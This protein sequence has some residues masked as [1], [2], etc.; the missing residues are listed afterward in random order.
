MMEEDQEQ[1]FACKFCDKTFA[2]GKSLGGHMRGHLA[3]ISSQ[4]AEEIDNGNKGFEGYGLRHNQKKALKVLEPLDEEEKN[5]SMGCEDGYYGLRENPK[6]SWRASSSSKP[7]VLVK[8]ENIITNL[9]KE[10]GKGFPSLRALSGHMRC[11]SI[12]GKEE[13]M[14]KKCG[15]G[16]DS[17]RALFGHMRSHSKR[18]R[19]SLDESAEERK[20]DYEPAF[21]IPKKRLRTRYKVT[22][23]SN[24]SCSNL[25]ASCSSSIVTGTDNEVEEVAMCL[26]LLSRG[27]KNWDDFNSV[28]NTSNNDSVIL[29]AQSL[30]KSHG[31]TEND[32]DDDADER[33][34]PIENALIVK[35]VSEFCLLES[36]SAIDDL[37]K[38]KL[39]V[40]VDEFL[41]CDKSK[42]PSQD[43]EFANECVELELEK[44]MVSDLELNQGDS[45]LVKSSPFDEPKFDGHDL[46]LGEN[47]LRIQ[48]H[49]DSVEH[50][51]CEVMVAS[52]EL[53]KNK[54]H[55]CSICFKVFAS[56]QALGG[57]KRAHY[58]DQ[59]R[60]KEAMLINQELP[61]IHNMFDLNLPLSLEDGAASDVGFKP[62]WIG[63]DH[64]YEPLVMFN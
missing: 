59:T 58:I 43:G 23:N 24:P 3:L 32:D 27:A 40:S 56:G 53:K 55:E 11:H 12:K 47:S 25:N 1:R 22:S 39:G 63:G 48:I 61:D 38:A 4:K 29:E 18:S 36:G 30:L 62:W 57:H 33:E 42:K 35:N 54:D 34:K 28:I 44:D 16:F 46:D 7:N 45:D 20:S 2:N 6:K 51:G 19:A 21:A 52:N 10:C 9:C 5:T 17:M 8:N 14:C 60:A 50:V 37:N 13:N 26:M 41:S 49:E 64:E 15:K 31:N